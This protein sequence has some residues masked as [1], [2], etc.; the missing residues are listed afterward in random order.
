MNNNRRNYLLS[1]ISL[2]I[3]ETFSKSIYLIKN[4]A[5][6]LRVPMYLFIS[7]FSYLQYFSCVCFA[8]L[9]PLEVVRTGGQELLYK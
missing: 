2:V 7:F 6:Y 3:R 1:E 5:R 9:P 8:F 4:Y